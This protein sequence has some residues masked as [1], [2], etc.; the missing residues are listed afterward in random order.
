MN[1]F[2]LT[3]KIYVDDTKS[4][5]KGIFARIPIKKGEHIA[6]FKGRIIKKIIKTKKDSLSFVGTH[7]LGLGRYKWLEPSRSDPLYYLNHS[8]NPNAGIKGSVR[9]YAMRNIDKGE[10][11][12]IDYSTTEEFIHWRMNC[13]CRCGSK[14][15]RRTIRSVQ[16]LPKKT[17][18]KYMPYIPTYFKNIYLKYNKK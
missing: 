10:E 1:K 9:L 15:C 4:T 11:I 16:F 5:G 2:N 18:N 7:L 17:F 13:V 8:C 3:K 12:T 14:N 6:T